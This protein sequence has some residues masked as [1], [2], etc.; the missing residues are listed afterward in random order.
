MTLEAFRRGK[1]N[2]LAAAGHDLKFIL[3]QGGWNS[4]AVFNYVS[5]ELVDEASVLEAAINASDDDA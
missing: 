1:A 4:M 2:S 5:S 3:E